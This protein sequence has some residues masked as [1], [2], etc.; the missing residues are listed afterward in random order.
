[1]PKIEIIAEK[2][3]SNSLRIYLLKILKNNSV[4][5]LKIMHPAD[6]F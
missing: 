6:V 1:M 3:W 4:K 2:I 5:V